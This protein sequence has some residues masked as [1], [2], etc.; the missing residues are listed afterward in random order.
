MNITIPISDNATV[1]VI[2]DIET[3]NNVKATMK[4]KATEVL[5]KTSD[6]DK[7]ILKEQTELAIKIPPLENPLVLN[8]TPTSISYSEKLN[9]RIQ[10]YIYESLHQY[11]EK[12]DYLRIPA[13]IA[14]TN[15]N[16]TN[17]VLRVF[18]IVE[19]AIHS[20]GL[21]FLAHVTRDPFYTNKKVTLLSRL[22]SETLD[23]ICLPFQ[24]FQIL[25]DT[26]FILISPKNFI[27]RNFEYAQV[28]NRHIVSNTLNSKIHRRDLNDADAKAYRRFVRF[29]EIS[30]ES[31]T[32][33]NRA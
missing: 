9:Y 26:G 22:A 7:N 33:K 8:V 24:I 25:E 16:V 17:V 29:E 19:T 21:F 3:I 23:I 30:T 14:L 28:N 31:P 10:N 15:S 20:L 4:K 1:S 18:S 27:F 13:F 11:T 12:T 5:E 32:T 2:L 6:Q